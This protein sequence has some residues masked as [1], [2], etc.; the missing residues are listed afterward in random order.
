MGKFNKPAVKPM[1]T[2][3][4]TTE[5][6]PSGRTHE[7]GP[8][9]VRS[10]KSELFLLAVSNMVGENTF[11]EKAGTRDARYEQLVGQVA[12]ADPEWMIGFLRWLRAEANMRSASLVGAAEAVRARIAAKAFGYNRQMVDAVMLRA[13]EPGEM[14]AYWTSHY[15]RSIPLPVKNGVADAAIRLFGEYSLLKYDTDSRG[16]RFA[17]VIELVRPKPKADWQSVL[18]KHAIDRRHGR[19]NE[20]PIELPMLTANA[21]LR[22]VAAS[23][24]EALLSADRL[25]EAGMT[26]EDVLSLAG[27][28][29]PKK[30]LW[31]ALIPSL[32]FMAALRNLRNMD[33]AGVSD[34]MA[35]RLSAKLSDPE[36]V[37]RSRQFPF[38]FL[39]AYENAPSLRW[40][41][42]LDKALQLSLSNLPS[43][44]GRTL[45]LVDTSASMNGNGL[46]ARST[47]TS[48]KAAAV[49]GVALAAKGEKVDLH[50]FADGVFR[51]DVPA[52]AGVIREVKRFMARTG[53]VGHGTNIPGSLRAT[54][55]GQDRVVLISDMQTIGGTYGQ[56]VSQL[57]P[58]NVPI[59]GFNLQGYQHG[60]IAT[61]SGNRHEF[62]GLTDATFRMLP[63]LE[64]GRDA[65]WPWLQ[66]VS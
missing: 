47:M 59:Y 24:P 31:E 21:F 52:G 64:A 25:T 19:A 34:G 57:V 55:N 56:G 51:H 10:E 46:S 32:P 4:I 54:F 41:H 36:Q 45:I 7:G 5:T 30:D 12:V 44:P 3:P 60:A 9:Y 63:L 23:E 17:D 11:Y 28:K 58:A 26:W 18:F 50:G 6:V 35:A 27:S 37:A 29:L 39:A 40:G 43:L 20:I 13:D 22:T 66:P 53:E 16:F 15:G 48:A 38:R 8:G 1:V 2:S 65:A 49:F 42:A 33:E 61:G 14:L 62:G